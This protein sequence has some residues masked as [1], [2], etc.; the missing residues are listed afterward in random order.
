MN[1]LQKSIISYSSYYIKKQLEK[2][3][4][5]KNDVMIEK[6]A[7][8]DTMLY[9][10]IPFCHTFCTYCSF[11]K[12]AYEESKCKQYFKILRKELELLHSLGYSFNTLYVGGGT[13]LINEEELL[14]TLQLCK[15]LFPI[16]E[17]S[18]ES[19]PNHID[20]NKLQMFKG[21][22]DRL[23]CGVQSFNDDIL[24]KTSRLAKFGNSKQLIKKLEKA[25]GILPTFSID[26]IFNFPFENEE[27][28]LNNINIAKSLNPEQI[29]FY[30]LMKSNITK[31]AIAAKFGQGAKDNEYLF[32]KIICDEFSDYKQ[33]NAW[34]FSKNKNSFNDE[35]VSTHHEYIGAGSGAFSFQ[36]NKLLI[37]AFCLDEYEKLINTKQNANI[38][39]IDFTNEDVIDYVFLSEFF[40]GSVDIN[41]LNKA[42]NCDII[43]H[44]GINY[45]ALEFLNITN[46]KNNIINTTFF[47][48]YLALVLMKEFYI[49]MDKLRE[50]FKKAINQ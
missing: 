8:K 9:I 38:S 44:L 3:F 17:I 7:S 32:Y 40:S 25:I 45:K 21:Y 28:L 34:S 31:K 1:L 14:I 33:N 16:K 42:Y 48:R 23:S 11:H 39:Y 49:N 19:D 50:H 26:L 13:T 10:H 37:N 12:F 20:E 2:K 5:L 15:K 35:Y 41:K 36:N 43:K 4:I 18:C 47:A 29:T 22:I 46:T 24:E 27:I 6:Q 30:P